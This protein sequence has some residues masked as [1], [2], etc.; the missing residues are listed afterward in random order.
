MSLYDRAV[1]V[2]VRRLPGVDEDRRAEME[3]TI[4]S[5]AAERGTAR[6]RE[7]GSLWWLRFSLRSRDDTGDDPDVHWRQ[8]LH[9]GAALLLAASAVDTLRFWSGSSGSSRG[10]VAAIAASLVVATWAAGTGRRILTLALLAAAA[11]T[12]GLGGVA[13]G[14]PFSTRLVL[15]AVVVVIGTAPGRDQGR[16]CPWQWM[17]LVATASVV[18]VVE[19]RAHAVVV[20]IV[21]TAIV[22]MMWLVAGRADARL[23]VGAATVLLWRLVAVDLR[24]LGDAAV[25]LPTGR[26]LDLLVLRWLVMGVGFV[27]AVVVARTAIRRT[28]SL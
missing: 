21:L 22:P 20:G 19:P 1:A 2:A 17:A 27:A 8:G 3:D 16:L 10:A 4:R 26:E 13:V 11:A 5:V 15:A 24:Q 9:R 18:V 6:W 25:A 14:A 12:A 7:L 23:A 28:A